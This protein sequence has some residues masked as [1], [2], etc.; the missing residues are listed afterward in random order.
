MMKSV[1]QL[2][3]SERERERER[4]FCTSDLHPI[5]KLEN[6]SRQSE[7]MKSYETES[8]HVKYLRRYANI[9]FFFFFLSTNK[10][11]I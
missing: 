7:I 6:A 11:V 3:S 2:K 4:D 9:F 10:Q 1:N 8:M 5:D